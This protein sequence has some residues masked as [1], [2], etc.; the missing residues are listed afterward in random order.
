MVCKGCMAAQE[1]PRAASAASASGPRAPEVCTASPPQIAGASI[2]ATAPQRVVR[3]RNQNPPGP[4]RQ[5]RKGYRFGPADESRRRP[6]VPGIAAGHRRYGF[7]TLA[8]Q[9]PERLRHAARA[10]DRN[11]RL[12]GQIRLYRAAARWLPA[13]S[14]ELFPGPRPL[15][16][17]RAKCGAT[18]T[19]PSAATSGGRRGTV[20]RATGGGTPGKSRPYR[21][22]SRSARRCRTRRRP[23]AATSRTAGSGC[24]APRA[25]CPVLYRGRAPARLA[26]PCSYYRP[27][28]QGRA[29]ASAFRKS[30]SS[31][32]TFSRPES[33]GCVRSRSTRSSFSQTTLSCLRPLT[34]SVQR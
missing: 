14:A 23:P 20:W 26:C 13:R 5:F 31:F 7:P 16:P 24:A 19:N 6:G 12:G 1:T 28:N 3:N 25:F 33:E 32:A 9:T 34:P 15:A 18:R 17:L 11:V 27:V 29:V 8:Q 10:S 22:C 21:T 2:A 4:P 30:R